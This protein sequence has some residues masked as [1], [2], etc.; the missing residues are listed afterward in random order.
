MATENASVN[1]SGRAAKKSLGAADDDSLCR[2]YSVEQAARI[3]GI[4]RIAAYGYA[5]DGT[6]PIIRLGKRMLVPKA[7][8]ERLLAGA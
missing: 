4:S 2:T 6:L 7:A 1:Q 8:L 5:N 3:L